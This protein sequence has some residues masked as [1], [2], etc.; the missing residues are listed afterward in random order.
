W[1]APA[2]DMLA[3]PARFFV[4]FFQRHGFLNIK[5]RPQWQAVC[6]GS[7]EYVRKLLAV[8]PARVKLSTPVESVRRTHHE[9]SIRTARGEVEHF[10][11]L[12]IACHADQ[13][14]RLLTDA[15]PAE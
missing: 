8:T 9:V 3:F 5:N 14:L 10:D 13:A 7:R 12:F 1:S 15:T 4:D 2:Q 11:R 6:G